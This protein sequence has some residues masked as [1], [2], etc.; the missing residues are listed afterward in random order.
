L[1]NDL[2]GSTKDTGLHGLLVAFGI[3][4]TIAAVVILFSV[5]ASD[6]LFLNSDSTDTSATLI[7]SL[8]NDNLLP[9]ESTSVSAEDRV[10]DET[11]KEEATS[12]ADPMSFSDETRVES[13]P[14]Q[15]IHDGEV[16]TEEPEIQP[17]E[18]PEN[19]I[20]NED[21]IPRAEPTPGLENDDDENK[22]N[23]DN[24]DD[25]KDNGQK[26]NDKEEKDHDKESKEKGFVAS[27]VDTIIPG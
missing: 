20:D 26:S 25:R 9:S 24:G 18:S 8:G 27:I 22:G 14:T 21:E 3:T 7:D 5:G 17:V 12:L 16:E 1:E 6:S 23:M 2:N 15:D 10:I 4:S 13:S 19:A 11:A